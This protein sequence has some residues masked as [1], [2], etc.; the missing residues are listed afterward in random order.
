MLVHVVCK[1]NQ[2]NAMLYDETILTNTDFPGP[3]I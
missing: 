2:I 1:G 3:E